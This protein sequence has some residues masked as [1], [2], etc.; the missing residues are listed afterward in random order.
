MATRPL[1]RK[2]LERAVRKRLKELG[3]IERR[4]LAWYHEVGR[5]V[6]ELFPTREHGQGQMAALA[7]DLG[8]ISLPTLRNVH[9]FSQTYREQDLARLRHIPWSHVRFLLTIKD[10]KRRNWYREQCQRH[11]WPLRLLES[12][13]REEF[14]KRR[15]GGRAYRRDTDVGPRV[16]LDRL[17]KLRQV[18]QIKFLEPLEQN[19]VPLAK[20]IKQHSDE[21]LTVLLDRACAALQELRLAMREALSNLRVIQQ[22]GAK[23]SA[24]RSRSKRRRKPSRR[25]RVT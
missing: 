25:S 10:P 15:A 18:Y 21:D 5:L 11:A 20:Q 16:A 6:H 7:A 17:L 9:Q 23:S 3:E 19:L 1:Q 2:S 13:V 12:K 24:S 14:G 22:A 4:D 8:Y